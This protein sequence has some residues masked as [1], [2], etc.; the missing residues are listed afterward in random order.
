M[1]AGAGILGEYK[2]SQAREV[3]MTLEEYEAVRA[4]QV[5]SE[6]QPSLTEVAADHDAKVP[7]TAYATEGQQGYMSTDPEEEDE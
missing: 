6:A 1:M 2:G 3:L 7:E 5:T 4:Q